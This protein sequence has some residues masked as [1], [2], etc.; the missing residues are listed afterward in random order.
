M[1]VVLLAGCPFSRPRYGVSEYVFQLA[2][3]LSNMNVETH[4]V[5]VS[6]ATTKEFSNA[7]FHPIPRSPIYYALPPLA[8]SAIIKRVNAK[9]GR[10]HV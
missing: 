9:I 4:L 1:R 3:A 7:K 8:V 2:K 6:N 5:S 10:A